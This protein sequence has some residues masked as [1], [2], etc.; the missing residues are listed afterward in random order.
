MNV[1]CADCSATDLESDYEAEACEGCE[2]WHY[3]YDCAMDRRKYPPYHLHCEACE[4]DYNDAMSEYDG[5]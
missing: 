4:L 5:E 1:D 2:E 3:C